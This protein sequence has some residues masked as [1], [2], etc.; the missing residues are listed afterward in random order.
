MEITL[1]GTKQTFTK[2]NLLELAQEY[3]FAEKKGIAVAINDSIIPRDEW[4]D[5]AINTNDTILL[6]TA[7][8]GG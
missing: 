3:S 6:I 1:N 2:S 7:T 5:A 8:A 4:K